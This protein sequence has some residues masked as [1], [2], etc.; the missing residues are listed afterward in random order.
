M[1]RRR[2]LIRVRK[3]GGLVVVVRRRRGRWSGVVVALGGVGC[4]RSQVGC[5][6]NRTFFFFMWMLGS[7]VLLLLIGI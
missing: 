5:A 4:S 3:A 7:V 2:V 6:G 1:E